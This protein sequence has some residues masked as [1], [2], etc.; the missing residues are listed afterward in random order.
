MPHRPKAPARS[1]SPQKSDHHWALRAGALVTALALVALAGWAAWAFL[2]RPLA[3]ASDRPEL[4]ALRSK[5]LQVQ[6]AIRPIAVSFTSRP[7]TEPLDLAAYERRI[8][9][10]NRTVESVNSIPLT[11]TRALEIRDSV[12]NGGSDVLAGFQ[13][14]LDAMKSDDA[15]AAD[16][17]G[18][19][20]D[21]GLTELDSAQQ[22]LDRLLGPSPSS[23]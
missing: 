15:T 21:Q 18:Q 11:S 7:A 9:V 3:A 20:V 22:Q 16:A 14:A 12:L 5:L 6:S 10:A 23:S 19:L 13:Q 4:V 17:A 2:N 1:G 8:N